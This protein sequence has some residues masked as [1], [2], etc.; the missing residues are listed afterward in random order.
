MGKKRSRRVLL[1]R[2]LSA[3]MAVLLVISVFGTQCAITYSGTL[4]MYLGTTTSKI[5]YPENMSEED[6]TYYK[7]AYGDFSAENLQLLI[8]DTYDESV[9]EQEEGSVLLKNDNSALPLASD[10]RVTLFGHAW[11]QPVYAPGGG[12]Q[13]RQRGL[14]DN[15]L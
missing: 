9:L 2:G 14:S 12:E 8:Q 4:N 3:L 1:W 15:T 13:Q 11:V 5:V 7:S 6:T 10:S